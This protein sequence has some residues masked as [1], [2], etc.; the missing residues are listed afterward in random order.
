M[1]RTFS[2][3]GIIV[4]VSII[5]SSVFAAL[6]DD[7]SGAQRGT[8]APVRWWDDYACRG[9]FV[10]PAGGAPKLD[11]AF[12]RG[13]R[14]DEIAEAGGYF[15]EVDV[16]KIRG[17]H[18]A[19][20]IGSKDL[21]KAAVAVVLQADNNSSQD[22]VYVNGKSW[23]LGNQFHE[24]E[25]LRIEIDTVE[26]DAGADAKLT[27][28][29]GDTEV[30]SGYKFQWHKPPLSFYLVAGDGQVV[31]DNLRIAPAEPVIE[32]AQAN[33]AG[34]ETQG[35]AMIEV[36]L[37]HPVP[38]Q[39]YALDCAVTGGTATGNGIDY[40]LKDTT[41]TFL[42]G[43]QKKPIRIYVNNDRLDEYDENIEVTLSK[44][45]GPRI[46]LG[47]KTKHNYVIYDRWP[48]VSFATEGT[49]ASEDSGDVKVDVTLSHACSEKVTVDYEAAAGTA[50]PGKDYKLG[51]GSLIFRP[52]VLTQ[53]IT[54]SLLD[55]KDCENSIDETVVVKLTNPKN[56][57]LGDK[58]QFTCGIIDNE[59]GIAFDGCIWLP[60]SF[61]KHTLH[62]G[63]PLLSINEFGQ[64]EWIPTYGA[65]LLVKLPAKPLVKVG[66]AVEFGWL[67]KGEGSTVGTYVE[68]IL[69]RYGS[70]DLRIALLDSNG[71]PLST[72]RAYGRGDEIFCGYKGYQARLSPHVPTDTRAD[73][74][75]KRVNPYGQNCKSPVDWGGC[76][77][78]PKYFNGHGAPVGKFTPLIFRLE[79]TADKTVEF[80][81]SLNNVKHTYVDSQPEEQ[82]EKDKPMETLYGTGEKNVVAVEDSQPK[83]IDTMAI[84]FANQRPFSS[85]TFAPLPPKTE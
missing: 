16:V 26:Q 55:D 27:V 42:P 29:F 10:V 72:N 34:P 80:S 1:G 58:P 14:A 54:I 33:S 43:E 6:F 28:I 8:W 60:S 2:G 68:N 76:W 38:D 70:G 5:C 30:V 7:F 32:F 77:G 47:R 9:Q 57:I 69:E 61:S 84:Y 67:Y 4:L 79:R 51:S 3:F 65:L 74:W 20:S 56:A 83:K 75:A 36:L 22:Q 63:K 11:V 13:R 23:N 40:T 52:G 41:L 82:A 78:Y 17:D 81:V 44:P 35:R 62:N 21:E 31:F 25:K 37:K 64:L 18:A 19:V 48:T 73:K 45:T 46:K 59:L 66:D 24:G 71:K 50:I 53:Q 12:S 49:S 15:I 85:I 39:T